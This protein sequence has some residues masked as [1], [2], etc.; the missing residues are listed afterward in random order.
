MWKPFFFAL[1]FG[2]I[3]LIWMKT[4]SDRLTFSAHPM[5]RTFW[6]ETDSI[7]EISESTIELSEQ[8]NTSLSTAPC[9]YSDD[10]RLITLLFENCNETVEHVLS[11]NFTSLHN[12]T[13]QKS[14]KSKD[15]YETKVYVRGA[16][17]VKPN[18]I[19]MIVVKKCGVPVDARLILPNSR[20]NEK[21]RLP[22]L[23]EPINKC[24][25]FYAKP[26]DFV[27]YF[28]IAKS[29]KPLLS[30]FNDSVSSP[31]LYMEIKKTSLKRQIEFHKSVAD[32]NSTERHR[33]GVCL[34]PI[35]LL[36]DWTL[37]IQFFEIWLLQ[38]VTKFYVYSHSMS[39]EVDG[40]LE[41]YE[42]LDDFN[43]ERIQWSLLPT[44]GETV[45][46]RSPNYRVYRTEVASALND[47]LLRA[48]GKIDYLVSSD[49]DEIIV[50][51]KGKT[52]LSYLE[53][54]E[55]RAS[56]S[57]AS[58][59]LF[60]SSYV[61]FQNKWSYEDDPSQIDFRVFDKVD[62]DRLLWKA[63]SRSKVIMIPEYVRKTHVHS[64][65]QGEL[66]SKNMVYVNPEEA[67]VFHLRRVPRRDHDIID[68]STYVSHELKRFVAPANKLWKRHLSIIRANCRNILC[69]EKWQNRGVSVMQD[70]ER[71]MVDFYENRKDVCN[72]QMRCINAIQ[73]V[74]PDEWIRA[75]QSWSVF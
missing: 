55:K 14:A 31:V 20:N 16:Y 75:N 33:L 10:S 41:A 50:P 21:M 40:L 38:G 44:H 61:N 46:D 43:I 45:D 25:W 56:F 6:T 52:V 5:T 15:E 11:S 26:C 30:L 49:L 54:T 27:G 34:Q 13:Q 63:G 7:G 72:S 23:M 51:F 12:T 62:V 42:N 32:A 65:L 8:I 48:K 9:A 47:C 58:S 67:I 64:I 2:C 1:I 3:L 28:G 18:E 19:R 70:L 22:I 17:L 29:S 71:C 53:E 69:R 59:F 37:L 36:A 66:K 24:P 4:N 68:N 35:Y 60:R 39:P 73:A 57:K 74:A